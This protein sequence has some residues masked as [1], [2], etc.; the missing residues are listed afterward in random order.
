ML[1][2]FSTRVRC[3]GRKGDN[4]EMFFVLITA[5]T[6]ELSDWSDTMQVVMKEDRL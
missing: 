6:T 3:E 5:G 4:D 2:V 1:K